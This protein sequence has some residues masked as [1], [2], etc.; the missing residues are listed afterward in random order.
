[1]CLFVCLFVCLSMFGCAVAQRQHRQQPIAASGE[2]AEKMADES[3]RRFCALVGAAARATN[4][5][6][7]D[8][9]A[10]R[11]SRPGSILLLDWM[12]FL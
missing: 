8:A 6:R 7:L 11:R 10:H 3:F 5:T 4:N 1:V 12:W 9:H 2:R